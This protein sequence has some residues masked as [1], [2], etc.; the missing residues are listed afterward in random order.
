MMLKQLITAALCHTHGYTISDAFS[1]TY[2]STNDMTRYT[3]SVLQTLNS[4]LTRLLDSDLLSSQAQI[5][6]VKYQNCVWA[7]LHS[8]GIDWAQQS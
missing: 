7:E 3:E 2:E 5:E 4:C 8:R 6:M 1:E